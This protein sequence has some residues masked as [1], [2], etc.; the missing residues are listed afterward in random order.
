MLTLQ[1]RAPKAEPVDHPLRGKEMVIGRSSAA[2]IVIHDE[3]L[4][5]R[6]ARLFV[7][8]GQWMVEDLGSRNGTFVDGA[9]VHGPMSVGPGSVIELSGTVVNVLDEA[10]ASAG[11]GESAIYRSAS[12]LL[13]S[14]S[15]TSIGRVPPE[16]V[17]RRHAERLQILN[18]VHG[19]LGRWMP[20][21]ELLE[22]ILDRIFDHLKPEQGVIYLKGANGNYEPA[23]SRSPEGTDL[24]PLNSE[25]LVREVAVKGMAALVLDARTD[26]R[27]FDARSLADA[28][29][30]SLVAA[31]LLDPDGALGMIVLSSRL[32][33][34]HFG[35]E[36]MELLVSLAS[37]AAMSI[38]NAAL[39]EE[40]VERRRLEKEVGLAR[41]IQQALLPDRLP[42]LAGYDLVAGNIP[43]RGVSGDYYSIC[44]GPN[45]TC[46][47]FIADVSGKGIGAALL[48]A[49]IDALA[50]APL[51]DGLAPDEVLAKVS[52][53]L[54]AR[55][56]S[57]KYAT[58]LLALLEPA[59]GRLSYANAGH[60]SGLVLRQSGAVGWM[61]PNGLPLGLLDE[62]GYGLDE[63]VLGPGDTLVLYTDGFTEAESPTNEL[64]GEER[65]AEVCRSHRDDAI[66]EL[67][68]A[69][70]DAVDRFGWGAP[71]GDD[72]TFIVLRREGDGET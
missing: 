39:A 34:R 71:I 54:Y 72:R 66:A 12:R 13:R 1:I 55:T 23:A 57:E 21:E 48:T 52:E 44:P 43:S 14:P 36:D 3:F 60:S 5:R 25:S 7:D 24:E 37:V 41:R 16:A 35:E 69:L 70:K 9:E 30:R 50:A 67:A 64:F 59:T 38:R 28:R 61:P 4:S 32:S 53:L 58:A 22:L 18:E 17:L 8:G 40:A 49:S 15:E 46:F 47:L 20:Q 11:G 68:E 31:P 26:D 19:A 51:A 29:V 6:H 27:F 56:P 42:N 45:G 2:D 63:V 65:L 33:V 62:G 10:E